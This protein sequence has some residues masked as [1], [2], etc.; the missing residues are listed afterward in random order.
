M[1]Q[2]K[3]DRISQLTQIAR[4]RALTKEEQ[5]ERSKL[6]KEYIDSMKASLTAALEQ[7]YIEYP[8]GTK[9]KVITHKPNTNQ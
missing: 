4:T 9:K 6:R 5:I 2:K 8:D 1:E 3:I 7:T